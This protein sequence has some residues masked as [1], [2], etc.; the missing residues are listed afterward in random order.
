M[1]RCIY[2][3]FLVLNLYEQHDE[4]VNDEHQLICSTL[5]DEYVSLEM[6]IFMYKNDQNSNLIIEQ[7]LLNNQKVL[8]RDK[9]PSQ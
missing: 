2:F 1:I 5:S 4:N 7:L 6:K 3:T 9:V 8:H